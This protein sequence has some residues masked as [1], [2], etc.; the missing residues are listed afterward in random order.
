MGTVKSP[1]NYPLVNNTRCGAFKVSGDWRIEDAGC[2]YKGYHIFITGFSRV[3][4]SEATG[5]RVFQFGTELAGSVNVNQEQ[6]VS[7]TSSVAFSETAADAGINLINTD[8]APTRSDSFFKKVQFSL[9][10][11]GI[12]EYTTAGYAFQPIFEDNFKYAYVN[13]IFTPAPGTLLTGVNVPITTATAATNNFY[14]SFLANEDNNQFSNSDISHI[15][16]G[17]YDLDIAYATA[18]TAY[19]F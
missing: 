8:V 17:F 14:T 4:A 13:L 12:R 6:T 11:I 3:Y 5:S 1:F 18:G 16:C 9:L 15:F 2:T 19:T 7:T 10:F